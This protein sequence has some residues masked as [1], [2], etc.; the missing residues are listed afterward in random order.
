MDSMPEF[1]QASPKPWN[2]AVGT[3][4]SA[5][6]ATLLDLAVWK[7]ESETEV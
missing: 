6:L 3:P 7:G 2:I 1:E 5:S 4:E